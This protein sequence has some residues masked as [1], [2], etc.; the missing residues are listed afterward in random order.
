[1]VEHLT[2]V[3][4]IMNSTPGGRTQSSF[5][6]ELVPGWLTSY[7]YFYSSKNTI[8]TKTES[9]M[10]FC[11]ST[12]SVDFFSFLI[13]KSSWRNVAILKCVHTAECEL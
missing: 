13:G 11:K 3:W 8:I 12:K 1:M 9:Y 7:T 4:E 6:E 10:F 5:S 2:D